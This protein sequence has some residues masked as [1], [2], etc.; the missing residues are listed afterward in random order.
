M[1]TGTY[2]DKVVG[3]VGQGEDVHL[4][5]VAVHLGGHGGH[6]MA[7]HGV[8]F[9]GSDVGAWLKVGVPQR[10]GLGEISAKPC[11]LSVQPRCLSVQETQLNS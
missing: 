10:R 8:L 6:W 9:A 7:N 4:A 5:G 1:L 11:C 3:D 2:L